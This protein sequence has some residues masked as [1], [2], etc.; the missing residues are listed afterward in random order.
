MKIAI[1]GAGFSGAVIG[2]ELAEAGLLVEIFDQRR[3]IGGNCYSARDPETNVMVHTY[4]PHIFHTNNK[5]VWDYVNR[6]GKF[7]NYVNRVKAITNNRVFS[8]P[9]NLLTINQFFNKCLS[10]EEAKF[11]ISSC[12]D[13][14]IAD[15]QTFEE[16]ALAFIGPEL[17]E[18]FFKHY[19]IKQW[20]ISPSELPASI[21][22]RLPLRFNYDD[23]YFSHTYQGMPANGYTNLIDNILDHPNISV[24]LGVA[25]TAENCAN[26]QH[27]FYSGTLDGFFE[28][29]LGRLP[30]RTLDFRKETHSGDYQGCAVM[31]YCDN[32]QPFTR[33]TEHKYFSPWEEHENTTIYKEYSRDCGAEDIP[34]YP[35]RLVNDETLLNRYI[36]LA[37]NEKNVSFI[38][39]LGTYRYL[40]MDVTIE[41]ALE[42][43]QQYLL[44]SQQKKKIP[45]FFKKIC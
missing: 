16:Q 4:G 8:L 18:A 32:N 6:F 44:L 22:K 42:A 36:T 2:R 17:Y 1:V 14:N 10:P 37:E 12:A 19:T 43:A 28:Y 3:H 29:E 7:N 41:E 13:K 25:F 31:N 23:N 35:V 15:P 21:L 11:F 26:Y 27:T 33:I 34:Y 39:R 45:T 30:Y 40:D 9:I 5:I 20:G 38:G 24:S